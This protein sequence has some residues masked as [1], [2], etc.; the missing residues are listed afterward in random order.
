[1]KGEVVYDTSIML[2]DSNNHSLSVSSSRNLALQTSIT[3]EMQLLV[4]DTPVMAFENFSKEYVSCSRNETVSIVKTLEFNGE[5]SVDMPMIESI[6]HNIICVPSSIKYI[7]QIVKKQDIQG[8][9][10]GIEMMAAENHVKLSVVQI[11]KRQAKKRKVQ[12]GQDG[13]KTI[14]YA[15]W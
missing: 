1:M 12:D 11:T 7:E 13:H 14:L 10:V 2:D 6:N 3:Q 8:K 5:T 9:I 4:V 15:K